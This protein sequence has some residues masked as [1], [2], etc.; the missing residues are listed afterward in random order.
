MVILTPWATS[1]SYNVKC[2]DLR[3]LCVKTCFV[4]RVLMLYF[5][6]S[7]I[8]VVTALFWNMSKSICSIC[9]IFVLEYMQQQFPRSVSGV[10]WCLKSMNRQLLT[11]LTF[12]NWHLWQYYGRQTVKFLGKHLFSNWDYCPLRLVKRLVVSLAWAKTSQSRVW[13]TV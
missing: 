12:T 11:D 7:V 5:I 3:K 4:I 2:T 13:L 10:Q 9:T 6:N 8:R 1:A